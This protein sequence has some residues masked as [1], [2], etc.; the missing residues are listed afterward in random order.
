MP[1]NWHLMLVRLRVA[2]DQQ[3]PNQ[4]LRQQFFHRVLLPHQ[5][6]PGFRWRRPMKNANG[7][8]A[9]EFLLFLGHRQLPENSF[10]ILQS[11]LCLPRDRNLIARSPREAADLLPF[12][13]PTTRLWSLDTHQQPASNHLHFRF[14]AQLLKNS[15]NLATG[16]PL[17]QNGFAS[18][19]QLPQNPIDRQQPPIRWW[20]SAA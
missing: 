7:V 12:E 8:Q 16:S 14:E 9:L 10:W 4:E 11:V 19:R 13:A 6:R 15:I 1:H 2:R 5:I 18:G 20:T 3:K 17:G